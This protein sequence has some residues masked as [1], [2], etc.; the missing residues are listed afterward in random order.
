MAKKTKQAT[1]S[2]FAREMLE[3]AEGMHASGI[4][5]A[6]GYD[7][8]RALLAKDEPLVPNAETIEAMKEARR[9]G[10]TSYPN[11]EAMLKALKEE[12]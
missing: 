1:D 4:M 12:D 3:T 8:I 6:A 5:D 7:R 2:R 11:V 9:G 10:L